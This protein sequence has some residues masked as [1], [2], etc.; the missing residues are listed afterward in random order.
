MKRESRDS[1]EKDRQ[2]TGDQLAEAEWETRQ[3]LRR[4]IHGNSGNPVP[5]AYEADRHCRDL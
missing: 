4:L 5:T 2:L 1:N 3:Q